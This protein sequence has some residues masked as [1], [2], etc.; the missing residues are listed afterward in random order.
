MGLVVFYLYVFLF[1]ILGFSI[2]LCCLFL[3]NLVV[4]I[5]LFYHGYSLLLFSDLYVSS[6]FVSFYSTVMFCVSVALVFS[7]MFFS[8]I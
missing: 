2:V 8:G 4:S 3:D 6:S 7:L 5:V 1:G